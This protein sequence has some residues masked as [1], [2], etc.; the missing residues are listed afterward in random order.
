MKYLINPVE[1]FKADLGEVDEIDM[2]WE[3]PDEVEHIQNFISKDDESLRKML[4]DFGLA[5]SFDDLRMIYDYFKN[6]EKEILLLQRFVYWIPIGL[7][8]AGTL[9]FQRS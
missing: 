2:P 7:I 6:E 8:I 5:M 3:K 1:S 4:S 9:R